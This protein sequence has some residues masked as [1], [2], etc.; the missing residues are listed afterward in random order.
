[1]DPFER[2]PS[3]QTLTI[4]ILRLHSEY[5]KHD[6]EVSTSSG[7]NT[8]GPPPLNWKEFDFR[9]RGPSVDGCDPHA[10]CPSAR[11]LKE[12]QVEL[13]LAAEYGLQLLERCNRAEAKAKDLE[14]Q[15]QIAREDKEEQTRI[16]DRHKQDKSTLEARCAEL[17]AECESKNNELHKS[18]NALARAQ[19]DFETK[20]AAL[21]AH[22]DN[23]R[24]EVVKAEDAEARAVREQARVR[25]E[26]SSMKVRLEVATEGQKLD[27]RISPVLAVKPSE[28]EAEVLYILATELQAANAKLRSELAEASGLREAN[29]KLRMEL[30]EAC[31]L[32]AQ[33]RNE[34]TAFRERPP[35]VFL[36]DTGSASGSASEPKKSVFGELEDVV[37]KSPRTI[38]KES[39]GTSTRVLPLNYGDKHS[40]PAAAAPIFTNTC[41]ECSQ[42]PPFANNITTSDF[43]SQLRLLLRVGTSVRTKLTTTDPHALNRKIRRRFDITQLSRLSQTV[44]DNIRADV[45]GMS[46]R[47][48]MPLT[49]KESEIASSQEAQMHQLIL[50][51]LV[52]LIQAMLEDIC[53]LKGTINDYA[54][55]YYEKITE[56]AASVSVSDSETPD[57]T[58]PENDER[59]KRDSGYMTGPQRFKAYFFRE[60]T[61][62]TKPLKPDRARHLSDQPRPTSTHILPSTTTS[63]ATAGRPKP[64]P[65]VPIN[66]SSAT[67]ILARAIPS[68]SFGSLKRSSTTPV[69]PDL[70]TVA[71][72][73]P[74]RSQHMPRRRVS[75]F[76]RDESSPE[77]DDAAPPEI[78]SPSSPADTPPHSHPSQMSTPPRSSSPSFSSSDTSS[79]AQYESLESSASA[80]KSPAAYSPANELRSPSPADSQA[81]S[82]SPPTFRLGVPG[83]PG[84][85]SLVDLLPSAERVA[86]WFGSPRKISI[87]DRIGP[88]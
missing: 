63:R 72:T 43:V 18:E 33:S 48:N 55:L 69:L 52:S 19:R 41:S 51:P 37:R 3:S 28:T 85:R 53:R 29:D 32:L 70:N 58:A 40:T 35:S 46:T 87:R 7:N 64:L 8:T 12:K 39:V 16:A 77:D 42:A 81:S 38:R 20:R 22:A 57:H 74:N 6:E 17:A 61:A 1:M 15:L 14:A 31:D 27:E 82:V 54:L 45:Q 10:P 83:L 62:P 86:T 66:T 65:A 78:P 56:K 21:D 71:F 9:R 60:I 2:D 5:S 26:L 11:A 67:N 47:F 13:R 23:L 88:R 76:W 75:G 30:N 4:D 25:A 44:I 49:L 79:M 73:M 80:N 84:S 24:T 36:E 59:D 34:V 68:M 50:A